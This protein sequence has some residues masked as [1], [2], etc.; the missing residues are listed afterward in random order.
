MVDL[1]SEIWEKECISKK[2]PYYEHKLESAVIYKIANYTLPMK[3]TP[4][5]R[6]Q[7]RLWKVCQ[8]CWSKPETRITMKDV[9]IQLHLIERGDLHP[10]L[11]NR[12]SCILM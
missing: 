4:M 9:V 10:Q 5:T 2:I 7:L 11:I 6:F 1:K 3:P 12:R 8:H